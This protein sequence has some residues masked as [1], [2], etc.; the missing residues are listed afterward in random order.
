M[1]LSIFL[2]S[3]FT[4]CYCTTVTKLDANNIKNQLKNSIVRISTIYQK[5]SFYEPW[6]WNP[7]KTKSGQG[8]VIN[9]D[10]V[11]TLASNVINAT[12]IR[13][14]LNSEPVPTNMQIKVLDLN[15]NLA[16]LKGNLPD[17]VK[18][19]KVPK[20][21]LFANEKKVKFYWKSNQGDLMEGS[22]SLE[23]IETKS[24]SSYSIQQ[25]TVFRAIRSNQQY[26]SF[27]I[28]VFDEKN[29]FYGLAIRGGS[30]YNFSILTCDIINRAFDLKD[31]KK[32]AST[33]MPGFQTA[34]LTQIYYR[35]KLG[36][37]ST[38]GACLI[39]KIY[40]QGSGINQLKQGD[41]ILK[42]ADKKLDAWGK[43]ENKNGEI[44]SYQHLFSEY[45]TSASIPITII[46]NKKK[47]NINVD[48]ATIN[49][50]KWLIPNNY[51]NKQSSYLIRGG[52]VFIPL[53]V[54]YLKE[55]GNGYINNAPLSLVE[56]YNK[57]KYKIK[58][59]EI[60]ELIILA[61]VMPHPSNIGL[62]T[63]R[64]NVITK[65]NG[66]KLKNLK[67]LKAILDD[68]SKDV[69]K[70]SLFPGNIPLWL[71][72]KTLKNADKEIQNQYGIFNLEHF[73]KD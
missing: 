25:Q 46:R 36:L 31:S 40:E 3:F 13:V 57:Y 35:Q 51:E 70:L 23:R 54:S 17:E 59:K 18:P 20:H 60:E 9:K 6:R 65:V 45:N 42:V 24:L 48:I 61:R 15:S 32:R 69:I 55:W 52:F 11:L 2:F 37:N 21:S 28:P 62:Q 50:N 8:I 16:I 4:L 39:S 43:Y 73:A 10:T 14:K 67:E 68:T 38:D 12:M 30:E 27:G 7:P 64:N 56:I 49:D 29:N 33:G 22:A 26:V 44:L 72:P 19:L 63:T 53:T 66:K 1:R 71:N 41:A 34:P 5:P 47:L 58:N